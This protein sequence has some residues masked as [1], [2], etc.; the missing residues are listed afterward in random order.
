MTLCCATLLLLVG[1]PVAAQPPAVE[2]P[3]IFSSRGAFFAVS[4]ADLEAGIRWYSEKLGLSVVM[5]PP[6]GGMAA[7][8]GGGLIVE[9]IEDPAARPMRVAAPAV[10]RDYLVHGIFK[11]GIVVDDW[12]GLLAALRERDVPIAMGPFPATPEQRAN[13]LIRDN[14]GNYLQFFDGSANRR[15]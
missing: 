11:A 14:E 4:V 1:T 13:L 10:T 8:E 7:L 3:A 6:A 9:L 15:P 5:R 2:R 12:E